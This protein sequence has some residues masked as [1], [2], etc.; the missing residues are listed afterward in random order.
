MQFH[1]SRHADVRQVARVDWGDLQRLIEG[2]AIILFAGRRIYAKLFYAKIGKGGPIRLK[3]PLCLPAPDTRGVASRQARLAAIGEGIEKG[4]VVAASHERAP[5]TVEAMLKGFMEAH[6]RGG[7]GEA[8]VAAAVEAGGRHAIESFEGAAIQTP[9]TAMM[10]QATKAPV[11]PVKEAGLPTRAVE[12][13]VMRLIVGL[14]EAVGAT[15]FD[16]KKRAFGLLKVMEKAVERSA[17]KGASPQDGKNEPKPMSAREF[18]EVV[19]RVRELIT[20]DTGV[21]VPAPELVQNA[22]MAP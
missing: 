15:G 14:E 9:V 11:D 12:A 6:A 2:E 8:C 13:G 18:Y 1:D 19:E 20:P 22:G 7:D 16:A 4:M 21:A 17:K 3:R 5:G 10:E